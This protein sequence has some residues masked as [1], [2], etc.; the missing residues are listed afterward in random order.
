MKLKV[1][2]RNLYISQAIILLFLFFAYFTWFPYSFSDLGGFFDTAWMLIFVDLV[3]GPLLVFFIYK[4]NKKYLKLDINILLTIQLFAFIYGAYSLFLKHPAYAVFSVDRFQLTNVSEIYP[5]PN[6]QEQLKHHFFSAPKFVLAQIP[7]NSQDKNILIFN[8]IIKNEPD[9]ERRPKYFKPLSE[10]IKK[11]AN[12][13]INIEALDLNIK[14][15]RIFST[16]KLKHQNK[17]NSL[18]YFPLKGNNH[19]HVIWVLDKDTLNPIEILK[20]DP[21]KFKSVSDTYL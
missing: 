2:L 15:K 12:K 6:W 11:I 3:L 7:T 8:T 10:H 4:K 18:S 17:L 20:I 13:G 9:I 14:E 19:K 21:W 5:K 1:A 16:F